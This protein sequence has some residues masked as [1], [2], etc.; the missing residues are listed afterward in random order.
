MGII[1][2]IRNKKKAKKE[3]KIFIEAEK[4]FP[5]GLVYAEYRSALHYA[6]KIDNEKAIIE[7]LKEKKDFKKKE[8]I[9]E[10]VKKKLKE[11]P[12]VDTEVTFK[13]NNSK[14]QKMI[15]VLDIK[16]LKI[17]ENTFQDKDIDITRVDLEK[18]FTHACIGIKVKLKLYN[19]NKTNPQIEKFSNEINKISEEI[20]K[21]TTKGKEAIKSNE[22]YF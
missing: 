14:L 2:Y 10:F 18:A 3:H 16:K 20:V 11:K 9:N 22:I 19:N 15:Y 8:I 5:E 4:R 13:V 1:D 7:Y 6:K 12:G 17:P 21:E